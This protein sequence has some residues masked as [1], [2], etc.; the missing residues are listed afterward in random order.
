[1][2]GSRWTPATGL[3][4]NAASNDKILS[5]TRYSLLIS[6]SLL[7]L[8]C[9][10]VN[11]SKV[12]T[13]RLIDAQIRKGDF[14]EATSLI[15]VRLMCDTLSD[16]ERW[17]LNFKIERMD[18]I[19]YDFR[20]KD[21]AVINYIRKYYPEV[22]KEEI[23]SWD[24]SNALEHMTIDGEKCYFRSAGRNL[25]RIDSTAGKHFINP[26]AG[27]NGDTLARLLAR[28]IPELVKV[29][30][31]SRS[32]YIKPVTMTIKYTL[33][34]NP[35]EVPDGEMVRVWLPYPRSDIKSQS[36]IKLISTSQPDYIISPD[37]YLHKS[38]YMEKR[39]VK[40]SAVIFS[41]ELEYTAYSQY[42]KFTAGDIRPYDTNDSIY[43]RYT[44]EVAPHI[45]FSNKIKEITA[46]IV[47][48]ETNPYKKVKLIY[49][50]IDSNFPWASAREYSTIE[51]IP[52]YVLANR[53][54]DCGQVSLLF[55][56]MA[57]CAGVPAKWQSGWMMHP[58]NVNLHD[59]AEVYYEG[60]GW[61]PVD[62][63]FGRVKSA[64]G[65]DE[66]YYFY[67]KGLDAYRMIV[68]QDISAP[69]YPAKIYPR[70]ETVDFQRGEV[71]WRGGNLYFNKWDY[72]MA[73][74]YR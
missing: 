58:G 54:G 11:S 59:W 33:T 16:N 36:G 30:E 17:N 5:M 14:T 56:T 7:L 29:Q 18:R 43:K 35:G 57:R 23:D 2:R 31:A 41:F 27:A 52:E 49:E 55:I 13:S 64:M 3:T 20:A 71:E 69:L 8:S 50:W 73:V 67:T 1:V 21:T 6:I 9:T 70:S 15:R 25:F 63:S 60:Y 48:N 19:R 42:F 37:K 46:K 40:D 38:L 22:T 65:N 47:G 51:N 68:N 28:H 66:A 39:A 34:V 45:V 62:Q 74:V 10:G 26:D 12:P 44:S 72:N 24:K 4:T 32:P 53:H 61:V